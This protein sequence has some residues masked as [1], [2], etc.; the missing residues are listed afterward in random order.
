M[1]NHEIGTSESLRNPLSVVTRLLQDSCQHSYQEITALLSRDYSTPD[2]RLQHPYQE[3]V[4][5]LLIR[6]HKTPDKRLQHSYQ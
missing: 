1:F 3:I 6:D 5:A 2:K 4:I